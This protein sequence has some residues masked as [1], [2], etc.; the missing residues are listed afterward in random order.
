MALS[1]GATD[2]VAFGSGTN[3]DNLIQGGNPCTILLWLKFTSTPSASW[4][5]GKQNSA[6]DGWS[7][8]IPGSDTT[9]IRLDHTGTTP[10][11]NA[12]DTGFI[13]VGDWQFLAFVCD[14]GAGDSAQKT[15]TGD[16]RT[17]AVENTSP[18]NQQDGSGLNSEAS[19]NLD[20]GDSPRGFW[21]S[22][23]MDVACLAMYS[24]GL[25]LGQIRTW[26]FAPQNLT[27]NSEIFC[28]LGL[29]GTGTQPDWSGN[30]NNG[31]VTGATQS[32]HVPLPIF[33][34]RIWTP[35]EI[36]TDERLAPE[37]FQP[38]LDIPIRR[39]DL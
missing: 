37:I 1:F 10:L 5:L 24:E 36:V 20:L 39:L 13:S 35:D 33:P 14:Q 18:I 19:F 4:V 3:I 22:A 28:H 23:P 2:L 29:R 31:A 15:F 12:T 38:K 17:E 9:A 34:H 8:F 21:D 30:R 32:A 6:A 27:P 11:Q 16:P 7:I 26:Q 25:N